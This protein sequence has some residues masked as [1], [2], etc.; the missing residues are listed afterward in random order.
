M[1]SLPGRSIRLSGP[2][3]SGGTA[4]SARCIGSVRAA[5]A[6]M[7]L[8]T[9]CGPSLGATGSNAP[10]SAAPATMCEPTSS[11]DAAGVLTANGVF[12]VLGDTT[13]SSAIAM[14]EPL[15][16]VHR[17]AK[18]QDG[19]ALRFDDI[20]HSSPATWVSYSVVARDHDNP[21]GAFAFEAGWKPIGFAASCWR[22][23]GGGGGTG[24]RVFVR[25]P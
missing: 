13:M 12:G 11:R 3:D 21:W 8:V 5:L 9:A 22:A 4:A 1:S 10:I 17:G 2:P 6:L 18:A 15:V 16:I 25:A 23:I 20:G 19:L 7:L 24:P 14:N